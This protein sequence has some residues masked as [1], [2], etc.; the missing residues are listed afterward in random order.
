MSDDIV[1]RLRTVLPC[2]CD[3]E[4]V[5]WE[6]QAERYEAAGEIERLRE[7]V[8]RLGSFIHPIGTAMYGMENMYE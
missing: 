4:P 6:I 1:T 2:Y 8:A 3:D 7:E 5:R